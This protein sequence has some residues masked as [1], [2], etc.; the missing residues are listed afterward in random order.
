MISQA[1]IR[2]ALFLVVFIK[3]LFSHKAWPHAA[4]K[5]E[6]KLLV[7]T[8]PWSCGPCRPHQMSVCEV[9]P[10][11]ESA[12]SDGLFPD[13]L[14]SLLLGHVSIPPP[15]P[16]EAQEGSHRKVHSM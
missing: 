8:W 3:P 5:S 14:P 11:P 2:M 6:W 13:L 9:V 12:S 7:M 1:K 15:R 16:Q 10:V 4:D